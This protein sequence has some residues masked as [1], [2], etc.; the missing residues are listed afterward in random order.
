MDLSCYVSYST[1]V[2]GQNWQTRQEQSPL[3]QSSNF[4]ATGI[5][6]RKPLASD[7]FSLG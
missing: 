5:K 1:I 7:S 6:A 3:T 2:Y 4:I